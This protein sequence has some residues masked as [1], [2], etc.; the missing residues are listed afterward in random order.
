MAIKNGDEASF[1]CLFRKYYPIL[2]AYANRFIHLEDAES[3]VQDLMIW[4]WENRESIII[5]SSLKNYLFR[6]TYN[7]VLNAIT[8]KEVE[9]KAIAEFYL[10]QELSTDIS[11]FQIEQLTKKVEEA[12]YKLPESYREA[13]VMHRFQN[14]TYKEIA[15]ML[16]VSPKTIDYRIQQA[17]KSLRI[18]L[19]DYL[20]L[21]SIVIPQLL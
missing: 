1:D 13:F 4:I 2:V 20:P 15:S 9:K 14:Y 18:E 17:L 7:R 16:N 21:I 12:I 5:E 19:K 8:K 10:Q 6:S 3:I 11:Y